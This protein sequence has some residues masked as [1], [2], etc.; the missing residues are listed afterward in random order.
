MENAYALAE[1]ARGALFFAQILVHELGSTFDHERF[2]QA[3]G[4]DVKTILRELRKSVDLFVKYAYCGRDTVC[5]ILRFKIQS[6]I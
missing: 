2:H 5:S 4:T 3:V 6:L 1:Q